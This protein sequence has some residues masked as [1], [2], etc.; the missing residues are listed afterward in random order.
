MPLAL[1]ACAA[2]PLYAYFKGHPVRIRY[3][4]PLVAACAAIIGSGVALLPRRLQPLAG[5]AV[6]I[7]SVWQVH[8][9]DDNAP[10]VV[11]SQREAPNLEGRR[12]VTGYLAQHWDGQPILMSM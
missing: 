3:D 5:A 9:L 11:E 6:I 12:A 1:A 2:L 4:V 10:V 7:L 8:P